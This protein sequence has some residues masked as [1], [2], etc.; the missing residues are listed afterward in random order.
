MM[1]LS[2]I[3]LV[4]W[5]LFGREDLDI[6]GDAA[7]LGK[8]RSGKST[9]IDLIQTVMTGGSRRYY[10][11]NRSAGESSGGRS[12]R[13]LRGYCLGQLNEHEFLRE[14]A[15]THIALVF[16]DPDGLRPP[17]SVGLCL[18]ATLQE[19]TQIVGRY[20]APGIR[21]DSTL[22][23]ES[24]GGGH[25][26]SAP[27]TLVH[28]RLSQAC[29]IKGTTLLKPD[30]P[31]NHIREYMRLLFTG[32][33]PTD[34]ERFARA[35]V[36]A[37]SFEDMRSVE[38]FVHNFLLEKNDIDIGEL[39]E[40]I[41]RY[42]DIQKDIHELERRL[43]AL[44][45]L[46][47]LVET[48]SS[49]LEREEVA[50]GV[51]RLAALI[52]AGSVLLLNLA[53]RR[54]NR[55]ALDDIK[56][57]IGRYD[58]ELG[59]LRD[60]YESLQTQMAAQDAAS[61]RSVVTSELKALEHARTAVA[62]RLQARFLGVARAATLLDAK[63]RLAPLK[64]GVLIQAI[65]AIKTK[66][67]GLSPPAWPRDPHEMERLIAAARY[68]A[69]ANLPKVLE[70]RDE[71]ITWRRNIQNTVD[72]LVER[73]TRARSG[74]VALEDP[75]SRLMEVLEREGMR[76]RALCQ[77]TE[78][79]DEEWRE[80]A[81]AL[82]GRDREAII[83]DPDHAARAVEILRGGRD[84]Y[85]GCR[86]AN[87]RKLAG[88]P[89]HA[90]AGTLASI[91]RSDDP[92]AMAFII[93]RAGTVRLAETQ[94]ELLSGG[95][96]IM[97]DG[98]Y[99]DGIVVSIMRTQDL[100][101]G[102]AAAPLMQNELTHQIEEQRG[103]IANHVAAE[104]FHDDIGKRLEA[105]M[106]PIT[107]EHSL[108]Q[109]SMKIDQLDERRSELQA[110]LDRIAA[111]IDPALKAAIEK[112]IAQ[113]REFEGE[114]QTL[115]E[116]RGALTSEG[117][118]IE[119]RLGAGEGQPGSWL[120]LTARRRLFR[121]RVS[122]RAQ[123]AMLRDNYRAQR[124][125]AL[126]R[127]MQD[128]ARQAEEA[129]DAYRACEGEIREALGHYRVNFDNSAP[130]AMQ[131]KITA[132][133]KPWVAEN[134]I[135][136]EG[137]ELIRYRRQ[138]DEAADQI[139]RLFRTAFINELNTRFNDLKTELDNLGRALKTRPL[140]GEIYTLHARPKEEFAA[141]HR[142]ARESE[143][144]EDLFGALF[145]RGS[146]RNENH[147]QALA[148][149][150]RL[151]S[152]QALDFSAY[153]DYRNYFTFDLRMQDIE[154]GR[155]TSY[156]RRRGVASGAERQVPFYVVIGAAL[157]SIYH[158]AR[159][160]YDRADLGL[161]LAVFDEAFSK[162]DGPNQRTLLDFYN[163]I[164]LQVVIAAPSEKRSV[165]YE[166]L[167][168]IVDVFR[169]GDIATAETARIKPHARIQMRAANPQHMSDEDL[170]AKFDISRSDA[171]E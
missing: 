6:S 48:F 46:Q 51:E 63:E 96:A 76:P 30:S 163:D 81:E 124:P 104:R 41:Q 54:K 129:K 90:D 135:A 110:R 157:S 44:R 22:L 140:H 106:A 78:V 128:M 13:T 59:L 162:M 138:A 143:E 115:I 45:A 155:Q 93:F 170:A 167:D 9:L 121:G 148:E 127:V 73:L 65:E 151:L 33:R 72:D 133:V 2:R 28:E 149:V 158:G 39:R 166:N 53:A 120:C 165:V 117:A 21:I 87:T 60:D 79:V 66:T 71:A 105:M 160:Q 69:E 153:Q 35:F 25:Y 145:G 70:R 49:L 55:A 77:I 50:R 89:R 132:E 15:V 38:S 17:V 168:S 154:K 67:D 146:P 98:A 126:A 16:D 1:Q 156:D 114:K 147:A 94:P 61:Q 97:R 95:R 57:E 4:Q 83:V 88:L 58:D 130:V 62:E 125:R 42:R 171:A 107:P 103:L 150:E 26:R 131:G 32:R 137:N 85:R 169:H 100:K 91:L 5:H 86:V 68:A 29:A 3:V 80:A 10:R 36:M 136:L 7:I 75:T 19:D 40:S 113:L 14:E 31:R 12:E 144:N 82:L 47:A 142:L 141:L 139:S 43:L 56:A 11:F 20:V 18:E 74:Q 134:V 122:N 24:I 112:T 99:N 116:R 92:L 161:G 37:L 109:L 159:R 8:N 118:E 64:M 108:D 34:A 164:G 27:W 152:D 23:I 102:K 52:E 119:R 101:I 123:L 111:T 84:S